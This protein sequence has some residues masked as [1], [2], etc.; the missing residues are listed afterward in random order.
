MLLWEQMWTSKTGPPEA[1]EENFAPSRL[2]ARGGPLWSNSVKTAARLSLCGPLSNLLS[3][4]VKSR[5]PR[6]PPVKTVKSVKSL[7]PSNPD[8]SLG[9]P[10]SPT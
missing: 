3:N 6:R 2:P 5:R 9:R 7:I 8:R 4:S 10:P 1:A